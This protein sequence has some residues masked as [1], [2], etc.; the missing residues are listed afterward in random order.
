MSRHPLKLVIAGAGIGGRAAAACLKAAGFEVELY[1]RARELRAVGSA[2]SLMPNALTALERVGVR[3]DLTRAQAFDS[4]RFLT[5]RGRPIR[6]IDFGG[7]ARQLG[8]PRLAIHRASLQ[9]ALLEQARDCRIE[10]GVSATGYLRHADGEGVTVLCSDGREVHADVL[11]GADGFNSAIRAT[12]TGPERPTDWHYVIWRATPA[13]RHPKVTPGYVAHYWGRGQRFGLADIGEGNVYWWGT[14]NMPAE[15]AKDW[16]GGKAGIQRLYAGWA[17]EVQ[18]VIEATPEAD[19]SSLPA[20]DRPF[21][22]RWGDGPVTLLGDAAH[23]M[24]T[25]LGQGAAI[26]IEDAAVLAHCLATIDDPQAALRAYENRRRDRARAMVETSRALSRIEQWEHPLRTIARD[27]YFRFA[28][29][30]TFARQ[31]E[32]ALTFPGVE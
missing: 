11:I 22:E 10:L 2:L 28:P 20:Q 17:D 23:P 3:P 9:Q 24:L 1:E 31:N 27:L 12:M 32:L 6:A 14:R 5:R 4:L 8:Q 7:L 29:E 19:I 30:R 16:R 15:Q 25:S 13:F 21:L 18:A 26:A